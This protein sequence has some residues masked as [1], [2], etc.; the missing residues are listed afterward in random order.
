VTRTSQTFG[1]R[2]PDGY[3]QGK[4]EH[5]AVTVENG[6]VVM[7]TTPAPDA[8]DWDETEYEKFIAQQKTEG[9]K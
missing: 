5:I 1:I 3:V 8:L 9:D 4:T 7:T 2:R 6:R